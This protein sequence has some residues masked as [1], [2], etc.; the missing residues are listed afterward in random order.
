MLKK[1]T[2]LYLIVL[3]SG[4]LVAYG[5]SMP[6]DTLLINKTYQ[7]A[8]L[9]FNKGIG[10]QSRLYNGPAYD[11][12]PFNSETSA[13]FNDLRTFDRGTVFYDGFRFTNIPLLYDLYKDLVITI[14][15]DSVSKY[16]LISE[17][18]TDFY[19]LDH[20]FVRV[21]PDSLSAKNGLSAGFYDLTYD[22]KLKILV[23]R[24]KTIS[25]TIDSREYRKFFVP[26]V[27]YFLEKD[28][29][30]YRVNSESAF[31]SLFP[32]R[33]KEL[34]RYLKSKNIKFRKTPELALQT[35]ANYYDN[36]S[37]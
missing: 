24:Y 30:Y 31:L 3:L 18:V 7:Q 15:P 27:T 36:L 9:N 23:K 17:R 14:L 34:Q 28:N 35:L 16:S 33:K 37:N 10:Q 22:G 4:S 5:Q 11:F 19:H 13:Y 20:H 6:N 26:G 21:V 12:Y 1:I 8:V 2:Q 29:A 32:A 25:E